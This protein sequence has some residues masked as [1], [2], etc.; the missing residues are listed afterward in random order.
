[1]SLLSPAQCRG[2]IFLKLPVKSTSPPAIRRFPSPPPAAPA[3]GGRGNPVLRRVYSVGVLGLP[4]GG[5]G[6][7][8]RPVWCLQVVVFLPG[9]VVP[10]SFV[11]VP[12]P[13]ARSHLSRGVVGVFPA[14]G[15]VRRRSQQIE[16]SWK[17]M[18]RFGSSTAALSGVGPP[19]PVLGDF[20]L[21]W[22]LPPLQGVMGG[23]GDGAPPTA[24]VGRRRGQLGEGLCCNFVFVGDLSVMFPN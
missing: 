5:V 17:M 8:M 24:T 21:A 11:L 2:A 14:L 23:S 7:E 12:P 6:V 1:M 10:W 4:A 3:A 20:P 19:G 15:S 13:S 18:R 16:I 22:G 9:G